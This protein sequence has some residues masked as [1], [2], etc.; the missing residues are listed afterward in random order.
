[1]AASSSGW[2]PGPTT[3]SAGPA[4]P[5]TRRSPAPGRRSSPSARCARALAGRRPGQRRRLAPRRTPARPDDADADLP[6]GDVAT[7]AGVD[8]RGRR[9]RPAAAVP[10]RVVHRI[11]ASHRRRL[12]PV[13]ADSST[14][15]TSPPASGCRSTMTPSE[16]AGRWPR[17]SPTTAHRSRPTCSPASGSTQLT[18]VESAQP[19]TRRRRSPLLPPEMMTLGVSGTPDEVVERC[20]G[21]IDAGARHVSFGPPLGPDRRTAVRQLGEAVIPHLTERALVCLP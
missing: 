12:P 15:S 5:A 7:D 17:S 11:A 9:R 21:L 8:R 2:P 4:S 19:S 13:P 10:A 14:T 18:L 20:R 16:P 6:R 1:M 3:S